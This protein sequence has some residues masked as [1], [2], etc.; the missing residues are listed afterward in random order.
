[1]RT[2]SANACA[3]AGETKQGVE[4]TGGGISG[5]A[6]DAIQAGKERTH[7]IMTAKLERLSRSSPSSCNTERTEQGQY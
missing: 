2:A 5:A 1:M 4:N 6:Q 7:F 3:V